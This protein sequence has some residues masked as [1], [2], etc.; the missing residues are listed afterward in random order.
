MSL[1]ITISPDVPEEWE[2]EVDLDLLRRAA[3]Q[4]LLAEGRSGAV[5]VEF[6]LVDTGQIRLVNA[7]FRGQDEVTD[8][9]SFPLHDSGEADLGFVVPPDGIDRLGD[10]MICLPR[11]REQADEYGHS[12]E[13]ELGYLFVH[14][15]LHLLGY[16]HEAEEERSTMRAKEEAALA[17]VGL[18]RG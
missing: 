17:A 11:A 8:V 6:L 12:V 5:E 15:L 13:R 10:I 2:A 4:V 9:L 16:D 3:G 18:T 14:G 1:S 7:E